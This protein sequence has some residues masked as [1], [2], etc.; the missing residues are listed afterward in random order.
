M[1][2]LRGHFAYY[3]AA[4]KGEALERFRKEAKRLWYQWLYDR[5]GRQGGTHWKRSPDALESASQPIATNQATVVEPFRV[6]WRA[7]NVPPKLAATGCHVAYIEAVNAGSEPWLVEHSIELVVRVNSCVQSR[8]LLPHMIAPGQC[9]TA[10]V[11]VWFRRRPGMCEWKFSLVQ[12]ANTERA[13]IIPEPLVVCVQI[14]PEP[15]GATSAALKVSR[16]ANTWFYW[17]SQGM[18]RSRDG[19]TYPLFIKRAK[20]SRFTDPEG[21]EWIDYVM[22]WGSALLGYA[23]PEIEHAIATELCSG[24]ILSLPHELEMRVTAQ[25][26]D[27]IPCAEA[28]LFGKNG[29]DVCTAAIR[30]ARVHTGRRKIL[31]SGYHG[32]Q[33]WYAEALEPALAPLSGSQTAYRF[34]AND[35]DDLSALLAQ[36]AGEIAAV[37]LEPAAQIEGVDGPVPDADRGFLSKLAKICRD[38]AILLIFDEIMTGFRYVRNSVQ[39]ATGITPDLACFGK[40][41]TS[42]MPLSALVGRRKIVA[43]NVARI[44][45]HPTFKGEAYSFAAAAKALEIYAREDVPGH[46]QKFG[47][48]LQRGVDALASEHSID[49]AMTG[50]PFR[51]VFKF[52]EPDPTHRAL[53]RTLLQQELLKHGVLTFRGFMLPSLAHDEEELQITLEAFDAAMRIVKCASEDNS[54]VRRLEI[55][56]IV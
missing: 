39:K 18:H 33:D 7:H 3:G 26:C 44:F 45:Y 37:I 28:V 8:A 52:N 50:P 46:V 1:Q 15:P 51:T 5:D 14:E 9:W 16:Q 30:I 10:S 31:F 42:S 23:H 22:G 20:G 36:H 38:Q 21:A 32:W 11:Q 6:A 40:A 35:F 53:L 12:R 41:L 2:K 54:F 13:E 49:G 25:L 56:L 34:R 19:R 48:K 55:P 47:T 27:M 24:A 17:P 43:N 29:S 4:G